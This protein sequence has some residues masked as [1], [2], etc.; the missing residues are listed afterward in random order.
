MT[1]R[2]SSV[3]VKRRRKRSPVLHRV[4]RYVRDV[5]TGTHVAGPL[6]RLA[7]ER[8]VTDHAA[9]RTKGFEFDGAA[10]THA[11]DFIE[12]WVVLPDVI[13]ED[14]RPRPFH[15]Q[16][17][18]AFIIGS[19]FGWRWTTSGH[20]RFRNAYIEVG[21]GN[22]KTPMLAAV[23]L[24][25][26]LAD[27]QHAPEIYAAATDRDQAMILYRDAVRMA[28]ASPA[29]ASRI[30]FSGIEHVHNMAYGLGFFRPFSREQSAKSGTRPHMGLID[31]VHEHPNA[32]II[33]KI[34]A[35]AKGNQEA[36]FPEITNSGFDR[37]SICWQHHEHSRKVLEGTVE[38]DRWFAYVCTLDEGDDPLEDETCHIK[39]NPNLGV[40]IHREYLRDQVAAAKHIP[41]ET[42]TVLRLNF[43]VWTSAYSRAID[44][45]RWQACPPL[46]SEAERLP[47]AAFGCLDLGET[48][49]FSAWGCV[50]PFDD[51]RV[52]VTMRYFLPRAALESKPNRPYA[53]WERAGSLTVTPGDVTDYSFVRET[54]EADCVRW[55]IRQV[56]Y[57]ARSARET[58]QLLQGKGIDVVPLLQGFQLTEAISRL[59]ALVTAGQLCH[60]GD[61]ILAW[62][63]S[64]LV[65]ITGVRG[66]R[67]LAKEKSPEK[68]DGIAALVMGIEGALVRRE[69]TPD[70][71]YQ[72]M[73]FG[74]RR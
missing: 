18:Q 53:E 61:P 17:W 69:R 1:S 21:K 70:P 30:Q 55:G 65:L 72:M 15:L 6:V 58:A 68:I 39:V 44:M 25:G 28:Q 62:M 41:A 34:H 12:Q 3:A 42:N 26:L 56:F 9:A 40:S 43:C 74:G 45:A 29:L 59:L 46:P 47:V 37:T 54:I 8:H 31:E 66:D 20:R 64:N 49:D 52:A 22:G 27:G 63:A 24:Y 57:D 32:D 50:W 13:D 35:G 11:I 16:P 67:R 2:S 23:G 5:L 71:Q 73:F 36:L 51:G 38:D 19:L 14:G 60:G 7:C 10:A 4:D 48:D 33:N